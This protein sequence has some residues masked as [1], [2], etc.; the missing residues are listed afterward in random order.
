MHEAFWVHQ[1]FWFIKLFKAQPKL[2]NE[3]FYLGKKKLK[4]LFL[5]DSE[6]RREELAG[7]F[8]EL[9]QRLKMQAKEHEII[10]HQLQEARNEL[11][12]IIINSSFQLVCFNE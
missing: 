9:Q 12:D 6:E 11:E 3:V 10:L 7:Q 1:S 5:K 8:A 4:L 2:T